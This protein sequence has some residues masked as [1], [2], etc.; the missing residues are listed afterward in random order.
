M[1]RGEWRPAS[2]FTDSVASQ[3]EAIGR[4]RDAGDR[5]LVTP[6][7]ATI[8]GVRCAA[9]VLVIPKRS[10]ISRER[11][12]VVQDAQDFGATQPSDLGVT[13][14]QPPA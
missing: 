2:E 11:L 12:M 9:A 10:I 8:G 6:Y 5:I 1:Y 13:S 4:V 14:S 3:M 7:H